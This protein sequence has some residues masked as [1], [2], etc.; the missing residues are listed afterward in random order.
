MTSISI[1][2]L[3]PAALLAI[4]LGSGC[5]AFNVGKPE[6]FTHVDRIVETSAKP[7]RTE[8]LSTD[9]RFQKRGNEAV[10]GLGIAAQEEFEKREHDETVTV[11]KQK[12]LS[13]GLFPGAAEFMFV[14]KGALQPIFESGWARKAGEPLRGLYASNPRN[15]MGK[16]IGFEFVSV[17]SFGVLSSFQTVSSL[18]YAP[19][20][21][22]RCGGHEFVDP[23]R[24]VRSGNVYDADS[25]KLRALLRF[26]NAERN[27]IGIS[28]CFHQ[29]DKSSDYGN[30]GHPF[31]T[32]LGL[33]GI[34]KHL[35]VF[36]DGPTA[37][38]AT[39]IGTETKRLS[40]LATGP[41]IAEF[42][43][44]DLNYSDWKRVA[45]G[46]TQTTFALPAVQRDC[47]V[48]A[49]V[50]FREDSSVN[51]R[52]AV[53]L[54]RQALEKAAGRD[55]R[56]DL[57]LRGTGLPTSGPAPVPAPTPQ[58]VAPLFEVLEITPKGNGQYFVRVAIK[59][60]S[61]TFSVLHLVKPE[62]YR[63]VR[64][65]FQSKNPGEPA[66]FVRE[67]MQYETEKDGKIL[68]FTGWVFSVRPVD[69]GWFYDST[70][71]RG[72]VRLRIVGGI[73]AAEA[74]LWAHENIAEIV[75]YKNVAIESGKAPPPGATYRSLGEK[76]ENDVLTVEF[77]AVQ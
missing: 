33:V 59:D 70:S 7:N 11:R 44:P 61:K 63:L 50:S 51:G 52:G 18:I 58:P 8:V 74:E 40:A 24:I 30:A 5:V 62:V 54:T 12:R 65:D 73:P 60:K 46:E 10:V 13:I 41:F 19:F 56:F 53:E 38:P 17:L 1:H 25:P 15:N 42:K 69:N 55:W 71:R 9:A 49:V 57:V 48:E 68:S 3:L 64:E 66:Q 77:E 20:D 23:T 39:V 14:P 32:H 6:T 43:I 45:V 35:A 37:G 26:S 67:R 76:F 31:I 16:Y 47:T 21:D 2:Q 36:V 75:K 34:H 4:T 72:W 22:W 29:I 27:L 28:T